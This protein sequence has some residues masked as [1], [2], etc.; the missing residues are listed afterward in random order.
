MGFESRRDHAICYKNRK[1][2]EAWQ[3]DFCG[4]MTLQNGD[5]YWIHV[6][7]QQTPQGDPCVG[8]KVVPKGD[9]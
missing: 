7:Q 8:V 6:Y 5:K 2:T 4:V 1:K 9:R 3:C